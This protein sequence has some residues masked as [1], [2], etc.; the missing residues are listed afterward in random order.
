MEFL[1]HPNV[2]YHVFEKDE[3]IFRQGDKLSYLYYLE[4]GC[5]HRTFFSDKGDKI[6][7]NI[8]SGGQAFESLIGVLALY[9][10]DSISP[11]DFIAMSKC[12]GYMVPSEVFREYALSKPELLEE[13]L[14]DAVAHSR[15]MTERFQAR[16]GKKVANKLCE[17]MWNN[18]E[19]TLT[20]MFT[21]K[22]IKNIELA[23]ILGVH[24]VTI[25]RI[26]KSLREEG[27]LEK[28][29]GGWVVQDT[30]ALKKYADGKH[31]DYI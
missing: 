9:A 18:M 28:W 17:I 13:L 27:I 29:P 23:G 8:K 14:R 1:Q 10:P 30:K 16:Q 24:P 7:Y 4:K 2:V 20:G 21:I 22:G 31:L 12:T 15:N 3:V 19:Q 5:V 6:I 26:I 11:S 25:S